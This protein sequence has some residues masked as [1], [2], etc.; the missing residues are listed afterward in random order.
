MIFNLPTSGYKDI[1]FS[2]AAINELTNA[3]SIV[4]DYSINA[5]TP[6]WITSG[7]MPLTAAFQLFNVDLST[8][9]STNN[10]PNFKIRLR[11]AGT[12]MTVDTGARIT[13]NNIAL[14]G[15]QL[16]LATVSNSAVKFN[17]FPNP[18]VDVVNV[19]GVN[20]TQKVTFKVFTID[21]KLIKSGELENSQANLVDLNQGIYVMQLISDGKTE[22]KKLIKR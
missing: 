6:V 19:I 20:E 10:N 4:V 11:F 2:F 5:G 12:N 14:S 9:V 15:I 16:P 21:G 3:T 7:N 8:L 18:F 22:T 13:F 1:K 17:V